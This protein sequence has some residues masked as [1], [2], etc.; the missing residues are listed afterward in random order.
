MRI[1]RQKELKKKNV[2]SE[3]YSESR[4]SLSGLDISMYIN[5]E[6]SV[7]IASVSGFEYT[8]G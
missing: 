1:S 4:F 8:G 5:V 3:E 2:E 6:S 7:F